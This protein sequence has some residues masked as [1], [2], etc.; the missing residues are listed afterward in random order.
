M[1]TNGR[2]RIA[3]CGTVAAL[4]SVALVACGTTGGAAQPPAA[5]DQELVGVTIFPDWEYEDDSGNNGTS[6]IS[7][8]EVEEDGMLAWQVTG[9]LTRDFEWG[10]TIWFFEMDDITREIFNHATAISF[11]ARTGAGGQRYSV[12]AIST[13]VEDYGHFV[14]HFD[15]VEGEATRFTMP[16][17]HF[18]QPAWAAPV[19]MLGN[20]LDTVTSFQW[21]THDSINPGPYDITMWDIQLLVP[22]GTEI[23]PIE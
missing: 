12:Q 13:L 20:R 17:A 11:M 15:T 16:L 14:V 6:T 10:A 19:G 1:K 18:M 3:L 8:T 5:G 22:A 2:M 4:L 21:A 23:P 7:F 9:E